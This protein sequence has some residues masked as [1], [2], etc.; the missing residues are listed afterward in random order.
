M[1]KILKSIGRY[2]AKK[3]NEKLKEIGRNIILSKDTVPLNDSTELGNEVGDL[4]LVDGQF[5][6]VGRKK[7]LTSPGILVLLKTLLREWHYQKSYNPYAKLVC[8][9]GGCNFKTGAVSHTD[10]NSNTNL[11]KQKQNELYHVMSNPYRCPHDYFFPLFD[12]QKKY[13]DQWYVPAISELSEIFSDTNT[14]NMFKELLT[15]AGKTIN[16]S[17]SKKVR[18]W[19]STEH[20]DDNTLAYCLSICENQQPII[21]SSVK[22]EECY[23]ILCKCF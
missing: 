11:V 17:L 8:D 7:T 10:G 12:F 18:L 4:V 16:P 20:T 14:W 2:A 15:K 9:D 22:G 1:N 21:K 5:A 6:M 3:G 23:A 13:G 19:S